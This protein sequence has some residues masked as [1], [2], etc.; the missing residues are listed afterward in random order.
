MKILIDE[1]S[2]SC[3]L[4]AKVFLSLWQSPLRTPWPYMW[5]QMPALLLK[6][7]NFVTSERLGNLF[8]KKRRENSFIELFYVEGFSQH[9]N[10]SLYLSTK[11][12]SLWCPVP[13]MELMIGECPSGF[14]LGT[15]L[16]PRE[17]S[18]SSGMYNPIH[19]SSR[20]STYTIPPDFRWSTDIL[21]VINPIPRDGPGKDC[22]C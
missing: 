19:P 14:A 5:H 6:G 2:W 13:G 9:F 17:I 7:E 20:Q 16:G 12:L 8:L 18:W 3:S 1:N 22:Q 4:F 10:S 11:D 15:S 21:L